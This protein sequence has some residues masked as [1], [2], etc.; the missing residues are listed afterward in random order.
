M[1]ISLIIILGS[2]IC[3]LRKKEGSSYAF[4]IQRWHFE[5]LKISKSDGRKMILRRIIGNIS[6]RFYEKS[7][8]IF[9]YILGR[10][11]KQN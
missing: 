7:I 9:I 3:Y 5:I 2:K 8:Q 6:F 1:L 11:P 10:L 4:N